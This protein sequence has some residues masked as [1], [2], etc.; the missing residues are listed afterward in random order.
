MA[1]HWGEL[2]RDERQCVS[3]DKA[4]LLA[5][6]VGFSG[7]TGRQVRLVIPRSDCFLYQPAPPAFINHC[8][9]LGETSL[10]S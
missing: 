7:E 3:A 10:F 2:S 5:S 9:Q 8:R 1:V 6:H 4:V